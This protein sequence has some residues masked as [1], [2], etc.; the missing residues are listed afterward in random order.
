MKKYLYLL[1][2]VL[3]ISACVAKSNNTQPE[4]PTE[5]DTPVE[6]EI[7]YVEKQET[8]TFKGSSSREYMYGGANVFTPN[9][10][11]ALKSVFGT[12]LDDTNEEGITGSSCTFQ[13]VGGE[14]S[15]ITSLCVGSSSYGG[16]INF[17]FKYDIKEISFKIQNYY[18]IYNGDQLNVDTN[19]NLTVE[20][21]NYTLPT[22]GTVNPE[23]VTHSYTL[24]T[25]KKVLSFSNTAAKQRTYINEL[26]ITYLEPETE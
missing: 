14:S 23:E 20:G 22:S 19:A 2:I 7:T 18:K 24:P 5:P 21:V 11:A 12:L 15:G 13:F 3:L 10:L 25:K 16:E 6:P 8:F 4:T 26:T 1:P 17:K 9:P